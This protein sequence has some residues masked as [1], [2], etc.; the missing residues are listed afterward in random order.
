MKKS[1]EIISDD[2]NSEGMSRRTFLSTSISVAFV[3][4][5]SL[6][7]TRTLS[8]PISQDLIKELIIFTHEFSGFKGGLLD[9]ASGCYQLG[10]GYRSYNTNLMRFHSQ[11]SLSPFGKGGVNSYTYALGDPVNLYDPTGHFN[12]RSLIFG[13]LSVIIGVASA[14]LAPFTGGTSIAI[15]ASI[16]GGITGVIS[17]ALGIASTVIADTK[18]EIA[19]NLGWASIAFGAASVVSSVVGM[20]SSAVNGTKFAFKASN[21]KTTSMLKIGTNAK[22]VNIARTTKTLSKFTNRLGLTLDIGGGI[23]FSVGTTLDLLERDGVAEGDFKKSVEGHKPSLFGTWQAAK[24]SNSTTN[25]ITVNE[26]TINSLVNN[27]MTS[28]ANIIGVLEKKNISDKVAR[29]QNLGQIASSSNSVIKLS[30]T[31]RTGIYSSLA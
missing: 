7:S 21:F 12:I 29:P 22:S 17:G 18:P 24:I 20:V 16:I 27:S 3:T 31:I 14:V 25:T 11:D 28:K 8:A 4:G 5:N 13:I 10:N 9:P 2:I 30:N 23:L 1:K 15:G 19:E 26:A 6:I